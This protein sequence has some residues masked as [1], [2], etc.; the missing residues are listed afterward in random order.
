MVQ[1]RNKAK[2]PPKAPEKAPFFL[3][4]LPGESVP[5]KDVDSSF[6]T[7][8]TAAELPRVAKFQ[9]SQNSG[10]AGSAFTSYLQSGRRSGNFHPFFEHIKHLS[11]TK[12]DLEIR[13]LKPQLQ[14]GHSELSDFVSA[15]TNQLRLKKD[16]ELVNA[17]MAVF[18]AIHADIVRT[19]S[20]QKA[21]VHAA[22]RE[23]LVDWG[24]EQQ[25]EG[26]R[27]AGLV[28]YCRGVVGFLR[29]SR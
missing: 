8:G 17:W 7:E 22:L 27:L 11:P 19:C 29:S 14:G 6:S 16:F 3:P 20:D 1:E 18:L 5:G 4:S 26:K 2:D 9:H 10:G 28:G 23:A 15:L 24:Q 12:I 25:K 13:S 21:G